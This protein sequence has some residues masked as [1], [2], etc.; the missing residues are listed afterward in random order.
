MR[1]LAKDPYANLNEIIHLPDTYLTADVQD[2][3]YVA[4]VQR[5]DVIDFAGLSV[6]RRFL[7]TNECR[8][9]RDASLRLNPKAAN[10]AAKH[11][12]MD[13]LPIPADLSS[14]DTFKTSVAYKNHFRV[15][16]GQFLSNPLLQGA[17]WKDLLQS[18]YT[19]FE[20]P[21][22]GHAV[23]IVWVR[24]DCWSEACTCPSVELR[25]RG[26]PIEDPFE[27]ALAI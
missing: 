25:N 3:E 10:S 22:N 21:K 1:L 18:L 8:G 23:R 15:A 11:D 4:A 19:R 24:P 20:R 17:N 27:V 2:R 13:K 26:R 5:A 7:F 14:D 16:L 6:F 12:C 9:R